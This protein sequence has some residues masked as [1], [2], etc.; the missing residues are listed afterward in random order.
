MGRTLG[1]IL[2]GTSAAAAVAGVALL[3]RSRNRSLSGAELGRSAI[4]TTHKNGM[5]LKHYRSNMPIKERVG[6]LQDLTASSIQDP[7]MRKLALQ[8]TH[9]CKA[10]DGK[11]EAQAIYRW[12]KKNIRYTGDIGPHKIGG[13]NGPVEG[14]DLFQSAARTVEF[15]GGD[16]D[17]HSKLYCTLAAHNGLECRYKVTSMSRKG[18][19]SVGSAL[20]QND[21]THIY[22]VVGL[23]K[24]N[25]R[26]F[27][28]AD[29]TLPRGRFGT[30][31]PHG[32]SLIFP[33]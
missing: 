9:H 5:T 2:L 33:A 6:I 22:P 21:Y 3:I 15:R 1:Y 32:K 20:R 26:K 13:R 10:R 14:V 17:D 8:I 31:A 12:I 24:Q 27:V 7:Q 28:A 30:E 16:C 29:T 23:P 4:E 11:C 18:G 25:P 19:K